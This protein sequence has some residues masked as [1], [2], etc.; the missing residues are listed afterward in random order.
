MTKKSTKREMRIREVPES[1]HRK[2]HIHLQ[3]LRLK[4]SGKKLTIDDATVDLLEKG[5][6]T[7]PEL[8]L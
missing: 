8:N 3:F 2:V 6:A 4:N 5:I 7:V 1:T